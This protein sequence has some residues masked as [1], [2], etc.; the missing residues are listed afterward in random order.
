MDERVRVLTLITDDILSL[1]LYSTLLYSRTHTDS[2]IF[3]GCPGGEH[4]VHLHFGYF[5]HFSVFGWFFCSL[6]VK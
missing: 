1:L 2:W 6:V 3:G 4:T 5:R